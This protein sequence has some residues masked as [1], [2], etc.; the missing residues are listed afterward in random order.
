MNIPPPRVPIVASFLPDP[1][2]RLR[3]LSDSAVHTA[4]NQGSGPLL[5][6]ITGPTRTLQIVRGAVV[7]RNI[8]VRSPL[9][10][11]DARVHHRAFWGSHGGW[12]L[13]WPILPQPGT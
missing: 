2:R 4:H 5:S 9:Y 11:M 13:G 7:V 12:T 10:T 3:F 8:K 1:D 6:A